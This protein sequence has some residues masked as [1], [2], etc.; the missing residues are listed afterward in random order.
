MARSIEELLNA[1]EAI[2]VGGDL[3]MTHEEWDGVRSR[4]DWYLYCTGMP[5]GREFLWRKLVLV[6][7]LPG[8]RCFRCGSQDVET[9][10]DLY[11][12]KRCTWLTTP[13]AAFD[14]CLAQRPRNPTRAALEKYLDE[15]A[16][17]AG[18]LIVN[19]PA[20]AEQFCMMHFPIRVWRHIDGSWSWGIEFEENGEKSPCLS[21][22]RFT[23]RGV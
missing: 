1:A 14:G 18:A 20:V 2:P 19:L 23:G 12:C 22:N 8:A 4:K 13:E 11:S 6:R 7:E 17:S 21:I 15:R 5:I 16:Q 3:T 9:K 10:D